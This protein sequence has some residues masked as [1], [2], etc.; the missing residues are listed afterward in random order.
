[1]AFDNIPRVKTVINDG[2][3]R[4]TATPR[5]PKVTI[6]GTTD[7]TTIALFEPTRLTGSVRIGDFDLA[8]GKPSELSKAIQEVQDGGCD[9]VE[10][11][12]IAYEIT[13][14]YNDVT[15]TPGTYNA[16]DRWADLDTAYDLLLDHPLDIVLPVGANIDTVLASSNSFGYQLAD[17]C[18][19]STDDFD[20]CIGVLGTEPVTGTGTISLSEL[21]T[22]VTAV[23]AFDT[24]TINGTAF[25][26]F[27]G[28]TDAGGD[29]VPDTFAYWQTSD[30]LIPVGS[31]PSA[32]G[33]VVKDDNNNPIDIG[34]NI[35]VVAGEYRFANALAPRVSAANGYY[36]NT[37]AAAYAGKIA[38]LA[39]WDA[40]TNKPI[41]GPT[42][43]RNFS[44]TQ[45]NT[46]SGKRFV[47]FRDRGGS[48]RVVN[49]MTGAYNI[50]TS[51]R[52]DFVRLTTVRIVH[53]AADRI[54]TVCDPFIG[55]ANNGPTLQAMRA[56]IDQ[57]LGKLQKLGA[58]RRFD[59]TVLATP[60]MQILGQATVQVTLV[61]AFE[62]TEITQNISLARE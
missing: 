18:Q 43:I 58:L 47:V 16:D 41:A 39:P 22:W 17:L 36:D 51:A 61:P 40:P 30:N 9:N 35:S 38:S 24:S 31:P 32:D 14:A 54:R 44:L 60:A 45:A 7:R 28:V 6:L 1:M 53:D 10:V 12:V 2:N 21:S 33:Q 49:A 26:T 8:S 55:K 13:S 56:E 15:G 19:R 48:V 46:L 20:S 57:T 52:S 37:G 3:L 11:M 34:K 59:F 4:V 27:D 25:T 23:A 50:S 62:I 5:T 29:G 42:L